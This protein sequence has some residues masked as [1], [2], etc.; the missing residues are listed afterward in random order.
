M[1]AERGDA[2]GPDRR[3]GAGR[4]GLV[5]GRQPGLHDAGPLQER[6]GVGGVG[7]V[8]AGG[9]RVRVHGAE[10][11][12]G[13]HRADR[14]CDGDES[15]GLGVD[16]VLVRLALV[17]GRGGRLGSPRWPQRRWP[18]PRALLEGVPCSRRTP[19]RLTGGRAP[20]P[21]RSRTGRGPFTGADTEVAEAA[22][23]TTRAG[24][25]PCARWS[26]KV[27]APAAAT[28]AMVRCV[29][30]RSRTVKPSRACF[31]CVGGSIGTDPRR[32]DGQR[33]IYV[34]IRTS[35]ERR[36]PGHVRPMAPWCSWSPGKAQRQT[37]LRWG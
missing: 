37:A 5:G 31:E 18:E 8:D 11:L 15:A 36:R 23:E 13:G 7:Q 6:G 32:L 2:R 12:G 21:S 19:G 3:R 22:V 16:D 14:A 34:A 26:D 10:V 35:S 4:D 20:A 28:L 33:G 27:R 17:D 30:A 9:H 29:K 25:P 24:A 1:R